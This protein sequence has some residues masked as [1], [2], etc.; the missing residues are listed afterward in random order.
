MYLGMEYDFGRLGDCRSMSLMR[1]EEIGMIGYRNMA[2]NK[3]PTEPRAYIS[4]L[5]T[6]MRLG[7]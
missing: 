7:T 1:E 5:V 3:T 6:R 2:S 4:T